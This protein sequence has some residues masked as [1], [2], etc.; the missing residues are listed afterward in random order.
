MVAGLR[1]QKWAI[2]KRMQG[3]KQG[4]F[5][6]SLDDFIFQNFIR[7][8]DQRCMENVQSKDYTKAALWRNIALKYKGEEEL[9]VK[10]VMTSYF[11]AFNRRSF[12]DLKLLWL[13]DDNIEL[14]LPGFE[15]VVGHTICISF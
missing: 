9:Q 12:D 15:T 13:P 7:D 2:Y 3:G 11:A 4:M 1:W 5:D 10:G 14:T 8:L 6:Y